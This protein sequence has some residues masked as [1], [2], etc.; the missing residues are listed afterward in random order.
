MRL[1]SGWRETKVPLKAPERVPEWPHEHGHGDGSVSTFLL[2]KKKIQENKSA[3]HC[4]LLE[5]C[6]FA[7][8]D[9][10][11]GG[12]TS[13][14]INWLLRKASILDTEVSTIV[15]KLE[16]EVLMSRQ[17]AENVRKS[18]I[19]CVCGCVCV[20]SRSGELEAELL[21]CDC[22]GVLVSST[23]GER[24]GLSHT[25]SC[26]D[27]GR[28]EEPESGRGGW[29]GPEPGWGRNLFTWQILSFKNVQT[30]EK[31]NGYDWVS[32]PEKNRNL[33]PS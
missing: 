14:D 33:S 31:W 5:L 16:K 19:V 2:Q 1:I 6:E 11:R 26:G 21:G 8:T 9:C 4:L 32:G 23:D 22:R 18:V 10:G 27:G 20:P 13:T 17:T 7:S 12:V 3:G 25:R 28:W 30:S 29:E 15:K 24:E